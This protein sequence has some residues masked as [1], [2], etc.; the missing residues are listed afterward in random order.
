MTVLGAAGW[1]QKLGSGQ[2]EERDRMDS[3]EPLCSGSCSVKS[4]AGRG[5]WTGGLH[6][7]IGEARWL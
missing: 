5:P 6:E 1:E 3:G 7:C 2:A 4:G